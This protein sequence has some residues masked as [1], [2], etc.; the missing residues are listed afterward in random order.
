MFTDLAPHDALLWKYIQNTTVSEVVPK[1]T[2]FRTKISSFALTK[3][4]LYIYIYNSIFLI[5]LIGKQFSWSFALENCLHLGTGN[6]R[7]QLP[8]SVHI[9][10]A[11]CR[12][13]SFGFSQVRLN[14]K[15]KKISLLLY[16]PQ[17]LTHLELILKRR[18]IAVDVGFENWG[19]S[20]S[21]SWGILG[22][23][24]RLGQLSTSRN[25]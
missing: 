3:V 4:Y 14:E 5:W 17:T 8:I 2:D 24:L 7:G 16:Q 20:P 13:F 23:V 21:F 1:G 19:I 9:F 6:V 25:I 22:R 12:M 10:P 15:K 11:Y 18:L